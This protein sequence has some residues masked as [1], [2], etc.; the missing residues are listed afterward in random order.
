M[1]SSCKFIIY[2]K[3]HDWSL[4]TVTFTE[5]KNLRQ[6]YRGGGSIS[7]KYFTR[8]HFSFLLLNCL[9]VKGRD[10]CNRSDFQEM[11]LLASVRFCGLLKSASQEK[12]EKMKKSKFSILWYFSIV[13]PS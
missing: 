12:P 5:A 2:T 9:D 8:S 11:P 10:I 13:N 1:I 6:L 4:K 3:Y 7:A